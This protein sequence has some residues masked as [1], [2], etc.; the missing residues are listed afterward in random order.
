MTVREFVEQ[1]NAVLGVPWL[2]E[3]RIVHT[4]TVG[5][6]FGGGDELSAVFYYLDTELGMRPDGVDKVC[7]ADKRCDE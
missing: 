3:R 4:V 6:D 5:Q 7:I 1:V 2:A